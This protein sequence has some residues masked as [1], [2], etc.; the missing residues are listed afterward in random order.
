MVSG[1][2]IVRARCPVAVKRT[3]GFFMNS[4]DYSTEEVLENLFLR[5]LGIL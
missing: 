5:Q 1:H 2:S 4:R 3:T